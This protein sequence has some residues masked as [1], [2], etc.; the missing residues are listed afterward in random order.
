MLEFVIG[1][2]SFHVGQPLNITTYLITWLA[3]THAIYKL[4]IIYLF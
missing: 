3:K 4:L 2:I 1:A